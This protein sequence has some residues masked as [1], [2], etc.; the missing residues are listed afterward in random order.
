M[1]GNADLACASAGAAWLT[2][3]VWR[4][5]LEVRRV[6]QWGQNFAC[7]EMAFPQVVQ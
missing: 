5:E 2:A 3:G 7:R 6:L 4:I 1:A